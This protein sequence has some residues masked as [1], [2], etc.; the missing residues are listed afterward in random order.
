[1]ERAADWYAEGAQRQATARE[2][3]GG[4]VLGLMVGVIA[5]ALF[6]QAAITGLVVNEPKV[7]YI[8]FGFSTAKQVYT[9][10]ETITFDI[11]PPDARASIAYIR[12]NGGIIMLREPKFVPQR[13]GTYTFNALLASRGLLDRKTIAVQVVAQR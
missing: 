10:G 11:T 3:L 4:I 12:P 9:V 8:T 1:M 6:D 5:L 2:I 7:E 13:P